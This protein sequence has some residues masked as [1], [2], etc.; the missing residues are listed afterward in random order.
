M[1]FLA[2]EYP[3][4]DRIAIHAALSELLG[5]GGPQMPYLQTQNKSEEE[6]LK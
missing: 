3:W 2:V 5:V 1:C 6:W 4:D